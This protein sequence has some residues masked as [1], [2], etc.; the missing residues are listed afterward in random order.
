MFYIC[1]LLSLLVVFS[2]SGFL[3]EKVSNL[4]FALSW[5]WA[6]SSSWQDWFF[7]LSCSVYI[8]GVLRRHAASS[9]IHPYML[10]ITGQMP[11]HWTRFWIQGVELELA[12][13]S[14]ELLRVVCMRHKTSRLQSF[15]LQVIGMPNQGCSALEPMPTLPFL[16]SCLPVFPW[17]NLTLMISLKLKVWFVFPGCIGKTVQVDAMQGCRDAAKIT[18]K[19][20]A[21]FPG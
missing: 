21:E 14:G 18:N 3:L 13:R 12:V 20:S 11:Q 19:G 2:F 4:I 5:F 9:C 6:F 1:L 8:S 16:P 7:I 10:G 15:F 17:R